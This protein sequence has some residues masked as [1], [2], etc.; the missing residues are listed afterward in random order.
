MKV[1]LSSVPEHPEY[2]AQ[3]LL[4]ERSCE[5]VLLAGTGKV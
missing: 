1:V 5:R 3:F 2:N 4:V